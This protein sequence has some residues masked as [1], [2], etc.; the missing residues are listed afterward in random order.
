MNEQVHNPT[1]AQ[2]LARAVDAGASDM[3]LSAGAPPTVWVHGNMRPLDADAPPL[4]AG[5]V[6]DLFE[7]ALTDAQTDRL[8]ERGDVDL[9]ARVSDLAGEHAPEAGRATRMRINVHRQRGDWAAAVRFIPADPPQLEALNLPPVVG[10]W[11]YLPRGLVLVTGPTGS[12]KS[13]TL[14]AM[15]QLVNRTRPAHVITLEDPVEYEFANEACIIEQRQVGEDCISFADALRHVVRQRPDIIL[16]GE[17]RDR[18][19]I[20][21]ALTA[22]ETGHLVLATLHTNS[23]PATIARIIDAF[24]QDRQG[25]IRLQLAGSLQCILCQSLLPDR[26]AGGLLPA[27]EIL[28]ANTGI[29]RA[30][31]DGQEH[32]IASMLETGGAVGMHTL[33]QDLARLLHEGR[34]SYDDAAAL[35]GEPDKLN[36]RMQ[37]AQR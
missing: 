27:T 2:L 4:A 35:C 21:A 10:E 31:R 5:D 17:M 1:L 22:A 18:E 20:A 16:V 3:V 28:I 36:R 25:Q 12:G 19:T 26:S 15:L 9:S 6:A 34:I 29:R 11:A 23:A 13:T 37:S 14:A 7:H 32:Q 30:I 33:E 24:S 8:A